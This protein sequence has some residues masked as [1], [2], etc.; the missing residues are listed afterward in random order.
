MQFS[1]EEPAEHCCRLRG[2]FSWDAQQGAVLACVFEDGALQFHEETSRSRRKVIF[3]RLSG[4]KKANCSG[5]ADVAGLVRCRP[6]NPSYGTS[7]KRESLRMTGQT[8]A[9]GVLD[10]LDFQ[11]GGFES[12]QDAPRTAGIQ[13]I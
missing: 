8:G 6:M 5:P 7:K 11:C 13:S 1:A 4:G 2:K 3:V 12:S 9:S 10:F